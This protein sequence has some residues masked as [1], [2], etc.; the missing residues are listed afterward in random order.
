MKL[1][2]YALITGA[3]SGLGMHLAKECALAGYPVILAALP[4]TGLEKV[5]AEIK[6]Y[7][8][9]E[10]WCIEVDLTDEA[11]PQ[12]V[13][14]FCKLNGLNVGLLINN[15]GIGLESS[16]DTVPVSYCSKLMQLNM[17][18]VLKMTCLFLPQLKLFPAAYILNVS[19]LASFTP[20]PFKGIYSASKVFINFFSRSLRTELKETG[21]SVSVLCPGGIPTNE[22]ARQRISSHGWYAKAGMIEPDRLAKIAFRQLLNGRQVIIPGRINRF[23]K[24]I[25]Q[26]IPSGLQQAIL[27]RTYLKQPEIALAL[28]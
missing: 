6:T 18:A 17:L 2:P 8:G 20:I 7:P 1:K 14:E 21:I 23:S 12:T 25:M 27:Y 22:I 9:A 16:F 19:S 4:Q 10:A 24:V 3:S 28:P 26:I 11:G 15:A 5:V 13:L